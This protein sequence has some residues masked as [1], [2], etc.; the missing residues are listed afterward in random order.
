ML[1]IKQAVNKPF[2]DSVEY[3]WEDPHKLCEMKIE[4]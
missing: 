1:N 4:I 3:S 2:F